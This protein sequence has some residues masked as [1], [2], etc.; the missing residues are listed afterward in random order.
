MTTSP[1][2]KRPL[3]AAI[4]WLGALA[5]LSCG[6]TAGPGQVEC[7]NPTVA[8]AA[9]FDGTARDDSTPTLDRLTIAPCLVDLKSG[10]VTV[11]FTLRA[12]AQHAGIRTVAVIGTTPA[13]VRPTCGVTAPAG[14]TTHDG[15]WECS[16]LLDRYAEPGEWQVRATVWD[17]VGNLDTTLASLTV[18]NALP[19]T[20]PPALTQIEYPEER[21]PSGNGETRN[22][23]VGGLDTESGMWRVEIFGLQNDPQLDWSCSSEFGWWPTPP[24]PLDAWSPL[25]AYSPPCPIPLQESTTP[26]I[27][28]IREVRLLDM[29]N[30]RRV[31]SQS[32]LEQA[33]FITQIDI[34]R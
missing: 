14:G 21:T 27:W 17:S 6:E 19:D 30:N 29:R 20:A 2:P 24:T 16:W 28:T 10:G 9:A 32:E 22:L 4:G 31:Y 26:V 11:A 18:V 5:A 34:T 12:R 15:T 8:A 33:G 7:I 13:G 25:Q 23:I 1:G 3:P